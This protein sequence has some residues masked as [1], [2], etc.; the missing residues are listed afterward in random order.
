MTR[1]KSHATALQWNWKSRQEL[2]RRLL[3]SYGDLAAPRRAFVMDAMRRDPYRTPRAELATLGALTDDTDENCDVCF[4]YLVSVTPLLAV[5]LSM[6]GP[7]ALVQALDDGTS[8]A[9]RPRVITSEEE[10]DSPAARDVLR[11]LARHGLR[12]LSEPML[13]EPVGLHLPDVAE[14]TVY[15]ALFAPEDQ[16]WVIAEGSGR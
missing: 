5:R 6:V 13:A 16:P 11:I 2:N 7:Y 8:T 15:N 10:L 12:C 3:D 14:P 4:T 9:S 1:N